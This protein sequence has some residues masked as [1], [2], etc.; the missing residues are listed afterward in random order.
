MKVIV[1]WLRIVGGW[2]LLPLYFS[3][4]F[5]FPLSL[6]SMTLWLELVACGSWHGCCINPMTSSN[7][8]SI[9]SGMNTKHV[10]GGIKNSARDIPSHCSKRLTGNTSSPNKRFLYSVMYAQRMTFRKSFLDTHSLPIFLPLRRS[11]NKCLSCRET[12]DE[13]YLIHSTPNYR[14]VLDDTC[15]LFPGRALIVANQHLHPAQVEQNPLLYDELMELILW[16]QKVV[17]M[18]FDAKIW[19]N[20]CI[21]GNSGVAPPQDHLHLYLIPSTDKELQIPLTADVVYKFRYLLFGQTF[22]NSVRNYPPKQVM[23]YILEKLQKPIEDRWDIHDKKQSLMSDIKPVGCVSC[24]SCT[25]FDDE[26]A[27]LFQT[28]WFKVVLNTRNAFPCRMLVVPLQHMSST[29]LMESKSMRNELRVIK[30][31]CRQLILDTYGDREGKTTRIHMCEPGNLTQQT[32]HGFLH[33]IPR[34]QVELG[35]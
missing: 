8:G 13:R 5:D 27:P 31:I 22:N 20:R 18:T 10:P 11:H 6:L 30:V 9:D 14:I 34:S 28:Q 29:K 16:Y 12:K 15:Q 32:G 7:C 21:L 1:I 4:M 26:Q 23:D 35:I 25:A 17:E 24:V 2:I 33:I 19:W 3:L